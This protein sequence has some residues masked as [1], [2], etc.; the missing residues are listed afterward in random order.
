MTSYVLLQ[1]PLTEE[2]LEARNKQNTSIAAAGDE[3]YDYYLPDEDTITTEQA[4]EL[5]MADDPAYYSD[6]FSN[7]DDYC[8]DDED[9]EGNDDYNDYLSDD[10]Y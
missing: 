2:S 9:D 8:Y 3:N 1:A 5:L 7:P 6:E 4:M 10:D